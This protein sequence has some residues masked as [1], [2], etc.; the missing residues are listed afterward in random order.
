MIEVP[1]PN[2]MCLITIPSDYYPVPPEQY[3]VGGYMTTNYLSADPLE[4]STKGLRVTVQFSSEYGIYFGGDDGWLMAGLTA[5]GPSSI[6]GGYYALDF[7]YTFSLVLNNTK[8]FLHAE[9][10]HLWEYA[11]PYGMYDTGWSWFIDGLNWNSAV[12]LK[13]I[14]EQDTQGSA[15]LDYYATVDGTPYFLHRFYPEVEVYGML[16]YFM[17][18]SVPSTSP[19]ADR[20]RWAQFHAAWSNDYAQYWISDVSHPGYQLSS[21]SWSDTYFEYSVQ[22]T[23]SFLDNTIRAGGLDYFYVGLLQTS[24]QQAVFKQHPSLPQ[25]GTDSLLWDPIVIE[26]KTGCD[27]IYNQSFYIPNVGG[28]R[29]QFINIEYMISGATGDQYGGTSP[30]PGISAYPDKEVDIMDV[31]FVAQLYGSH[32]GDGNWNYM[33]DVV[34]DRKIDIRDVS[35]VAK[36]FGTGNPTWIH[37]DGSQAA[38]IVVFFEG[39][40]NYA[41]GSDNLVPVPAQGGTGKFWVNYDGAHTGAL[42]VLYKNR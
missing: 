30:Y 22:G 32:E 10:W 28:S 25:V 9:I 31:S 2:R 24:W 17:I 8:T 6:Y 37:F 26:M 34:P 40:S 14:W 33:A 23:K 1:E 42:L 13:M 35:T 36:N 11:P 38:R 21:G 41:V 18:S 7:G 15:V 3:Y 27:D 12:T 4:G 39:L 29:P 20:V 19:I 5:Q 16:P